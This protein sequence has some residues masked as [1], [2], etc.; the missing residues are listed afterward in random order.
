MLTRTLFFAYLVFMVV[1]ISGQNLEHHP[2]FAQQQKLNNSG[3]Y[4]LGTWA[5]ANFS[6]S[7]PSMSALREENST[8]YYFHEANFAWNTV[9][10]AIAGGS[11]LFDVFRSPKSTDFLAAK[12]LNERTRK[13]LLVN[14]FLDVGYIG[15]GA[16]IWNNGS[17]ND[18]ARIEGYGQAL[19]AQGAFLLAFDL[20]FY[21]A[22]KQ[23]FKNNFE[24]NAS[25][26]SFFP[27]GVKFRLD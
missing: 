14:S 3:M 8:L 27:G 22:Q 21:Y 25:R 12:Q 20:A 1:P 17:R 18:D 24:D 26:V 11:L 16:W 6:L 10:L 2:A 13:A 23:F 4:V 5:I 7:L 9:N 19:V 15:L